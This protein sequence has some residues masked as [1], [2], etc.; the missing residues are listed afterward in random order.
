MG[1][2]TPVT[3]LVDIDDY[4]RIADIS[5]QTGES[6]SSI[7]RRFIRESLRTLEGKT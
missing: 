6:I 7:I 2:K 5:R 3:V 4:Q 1:R